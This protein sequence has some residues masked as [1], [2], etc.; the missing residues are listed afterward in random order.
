[1]IMAYKTWN[2]QLVL[3]HCNFIVTKI[4][5]QIMQMRIEWPEVCA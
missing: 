4:P 5:N 3:V 2:N 1:M